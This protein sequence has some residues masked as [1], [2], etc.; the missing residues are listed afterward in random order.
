MGSDPTTFDSPVS[1]P[2]AW[3]YL[4]DILRAADKKSYDRKTLRAAVVGLVGDQRGIAFLRSLKQID[5]PLTADKIL[6]SYGRC[7]AAVTAWIKEGRTDL[8]ENTL[9]AVKKC[10]QPKSDFEQVKADAKRWDNFGAF[11]GDLPGDLREQMKLWLKERNY[12][13]PQTPKKKIKKP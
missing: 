3:K 4:S 2:R 6:G 8:L 11:I 1:N 9:L 5:H 7:R 13:I 12:D 10:L